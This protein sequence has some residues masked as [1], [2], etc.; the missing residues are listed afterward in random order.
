MAAGELLPYPNAMASNSQYA[1]D[2]FPVA[3]SSGKL[4][5]QGSPLTVRYHGGAVIGISFP[6]Y[7]SSL[8]QPK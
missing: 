1:F 7:F 8:L 6:I 5:Y 3:E 2:G 4:I